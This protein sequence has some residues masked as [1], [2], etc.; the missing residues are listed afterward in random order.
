MSVRKER[1]TLVG[2]PQSWPEL[3][4][5]HVRTRR[6]CYELLLRYLRICLGVNSKVSQ[7]GPCDDPLGRHR[8]SFWGSRANLKHKYVKTNVRI[9][10]EE[11]GAVDI[12]CL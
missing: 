12:W 10:L 2:V 6:L 7:P 3:L 9:L 4:S 8:A 11:Q 5:S 1:K